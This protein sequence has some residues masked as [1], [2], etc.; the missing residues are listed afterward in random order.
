VL[1]VLKP[2]SVNRLELSGHFQAC[3]GIALP[4]KENKFEKGRKGC[5]DCVNVWYFSI[6]YPETDVPWT[7]SDSAVAIGILRASAL[8]CVS[9]R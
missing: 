3:N 6:R 8:F 5:F 9:K 2:G 7:K 4:L 1:I